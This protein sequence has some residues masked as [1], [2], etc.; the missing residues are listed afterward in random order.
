VAVN[1]IKLSTTGTLSPVTLA[2]LGNRSFTH[3]T[4]NFDLLTEYSLDELLMSEDLKSAVDNGYVT[5]KNEDNVVV[6]KVD[7][8]PFYNVKN[9]LSAI[10][11]PGTSDDKTDGYSFGSNWV[12]TNTNETFLCLDN[13]E[14]TAV[15]IT[16]VT[17]SLDK[18]FS[19]DASRNS[20]VTN[21]YLSAGGEAPTNI[22]PFVIPFN[23]TIIAIS[24]STNGN[25]SWTAEIR[26][27]GTLIPGASLVIS[28]ASSAYSA[29]YDID[30]DAGD[31]LQLYCNGTNINRPRI[32]VWM[33]RR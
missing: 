28:A 2:D 7:D 1:E 12:N 5:L 9:N 19:F 3:P 26:E 30:L 31:K 4:V 16:P 15:W 22:T 14:G 6:T 33:K 32:T 11:D 10:T 23:S 8:A 13:S 29:S 24:A 27:N 21:S 17:L 25:E 18:S 20:N